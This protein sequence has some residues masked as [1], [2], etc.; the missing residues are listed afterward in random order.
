MY[1]IDSFIAQLDDNDA[2][3]LSYWDMTNS[4]WATAWNIPNYDAIGWGMT[5]R[6]LITLA[7]PIITNALKL[8]GSLVDGDNNFSASEIQ[9]FGDRVNT[10]P[11]P[12]TLLLSGTGLAGLSGIS[13]RR[14]K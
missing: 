10:V 13:R 9:A 11:E 2:Y 5:T 6:P 7:T 14:K 1:G 3:L 12:A 8:E 4:S